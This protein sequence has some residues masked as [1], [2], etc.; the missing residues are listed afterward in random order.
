MQLDRQ[1][2]VSTWTKKGILSHVDLLYYTL[3][4]NVVYTPK[5]ATKAYPK[6]NR[7]LLLVRILITFFQGCQ[8]GCFFF[9][10]RC[11]IV[12]VYPKTLLWT[13]L[14]FYCI[15]TSCVHVNKSCI[16]CKGPLVLNYFWSLL[17]LYYCIHAQTFLLIRALVQFNLVMLCG[18]KCIDKLIPIHLKC[19]GRWV[20]DFN[21]WPIT[22]FYY[23]C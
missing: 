15:A 13:N 1:P 2:H 18:L 17:N 9:F 3:L 10:I 8:I 5:I 23:R 4:Y 19:I 20:W 12:Q 14:G 21:K 6:V 22:F 16:K 7:G 11:G